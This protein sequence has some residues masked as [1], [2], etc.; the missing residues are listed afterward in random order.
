MG[1]IGQRGKIFDRN[2]N[3][4]DRDGIYEIEAGNKGKRG[5]VMNSE[6][7]IGP[8]EEILDKDGKY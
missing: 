3:I 6:G 5:K 4:S 8:R 2:G 7:N 1:N